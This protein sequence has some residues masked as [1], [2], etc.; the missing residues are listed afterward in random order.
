MR[1]P[2][3]LRAESDAPFARRAV[4]EEL[5]S[6]LL[7]SADLNPVAQ[8]TLLAPPALQGAEFRA[9][10]DDGSAVTKSAVAAVQRTNELIFIDP[11][12]PDREQ[13]LAGLTAQS[14]EGRQFEVITLDASR[15]GIAQVT[16]ALRG[17]IQVD[18]VHFITH[19]ADGAVQLGG[20]WLDAKTLAANA[21][22]VAG[23]GDS[24]K[25]DADVLF[26]GCDLASSAS[27]RALMQ[28][29]AELTRG[30]VAASTDATGAAGQGGD[31]DLEAKVG[32]IET[33]VAVAADARAS[34]SH[35]LSGVPVGS[36]KPGEHH[37]RTNRAGR[38][39]GRDRAG[40]SLRC[41]LERATGQDGIGR[42][43][44][45][46]LRRER[47]SAER[48]DPRQYDHR[49]APSLR[50]RSQ[51]TRAGNF[52]V[53]WSGNGQG[54]Q[55]R[56]VLRRFN[57]AGRIPLGVG[58]LRVNVA[59]PGNQS[60][61]RHRDGNERRLRRRLA[62]RRDR[63]I[64]IW[65]RR[66]LPTARAIGG[67]TL[68]FNVRGRR[69]FDPDDRHG[70]RR[71]FRRRVGEPGRQQHAVCSRGGT[72]TPASLRARSFPVN[73]TTSGEQQRPDVAMDADRQLRRRL[74]WRGSNRQQGR[75]TAGA[76]AAAGT[77]QGGEFRV[78]TLTG[79]DQT[80]AS[81]SMSG[82]GRFVVTW[83]SNDQDTD[84]LGVYAQEYAPTGSRRWRR[85]P[86]Q[87]H[88]HERPG[89][90]AVAMDDAGGYVAAWSGQGSGDG[91]GV[92]GGASSPAATGTIS[93]TVY[94]D[95][96][97]DGT[98]PNR[99]RFTFAGATVHLF[100]DDG[101]GAID[102]GDI[103]VGSILTDAAGAYSFTGLANSTY[104][105]VVDSKTLS[106]NPSVWAEQTYGV[107][108]SALGAGFTL[109]DGALFGGRDPNRLGQLDEPA[110]LARH[111]RA[112][113]DGD[114]VRR[115][116]R[117]RRF[118]VQLQ[119]DHLDS[120]RRRRRLARTVQGSLRQFIQNSNAIPN[121]AFGGGVEVRTSNFSIGSGPRT[122]VLASAL[123]AITDAVVLDAG[124]QEGFSGTPLIEVNG[125]SMGGGITLQS[126]SSGSV[127]RGFVINRFSGSGLFV[128]SGS[129]GNTIAGNWI[130]TDASGTA[131]QGNNGDGILI[132]GDDNVVTG[133]LISGNNNDGIQINGGATGNRVLGN[134]IG[135]SRFGD[136]A[137]ANTGAGINIFG[138]GNTVGGT[139]AGE[140][141]VISGNFQGISISTAQAVGNVVQGNYIGTDVTGTLD[142]GNTS[143]GVRIFD[144]AR[145]TVIGGTAPG[146]GNL[147]S[148]NNGD[149]LEI[150]GANT[151]G[152]LVQGNLIGTAAG[153]GGPRPNS[154]AGVRISAG[155]TDNTIGGTTAAE[156]NVISG[157]TLDGVAVSDLGTSRNVIQ[158]NFIGVNAA[159]TAALANGDA[160]VDIEAGASGN[161]VG[162]TVPGAGNVIS[163]N[164]VNGVE[165][166]G[167]GT[168]GNVVAGNT[169]GLNAV[170]DTAR[171]KRTFGRHAHRRVGQHDRRGGRRQRAVRQHPGRHHRIPLERQPDRGQLHRDRCD[172]KHRTGQRRGR[173][174]LRGQLEQHDWRHHAG[175]AERR[176]R[177][178]L[179]RDHALGGGVGERRSRELRRNRRDGHCA[180][181]QRRAGRPRR[182]L[183]AGPRSEELPP[184]PAT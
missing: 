176:L 20:T 100:R 99:A 57:A 155:A 72:T 62:E 46:A 13:L 149:G 158:G 138:G 128:A 167:A 141:N 148:G 9:L 127:V 47:H 56:R 142:R 5:E 52:V 8:E 71:R 84:N 104:Y 39:G 182:D 94:H 172:R 150:S 156:R 115:R 28:W 98:S 169:I 90:S 91:N 125:A 41:R 2:T 177:E 126:G 160:G 106:A 61:P 157:N 23:W 97:G 184:A 93:G 75:S 111:V 122:I 134:L 63:R 10:S 118:G 117:R 31:W 32:A 19:G 33:Q 49:A 152:N 168:T 161:V 166:N 96:D 154:G 77:P 70:R 44:R 59:I 40:R 25:Q 22:A 107:A 34:W 135:T 113:D 124:T 103:F 89:T 181:R 159:G 18:A 15:D 131:D 108:G 110:H 17:R 145:G 147:I 133:N 38:A 121:S 16:D 54:R 85:V 21:E 80:A 51:W 173:H 112:R 102:L 37:D 132:D 68:G 14:A 7:M 30:D 162:G 123:P 82:A 3:P 74:G 26:Y 165:L 43:V 42:R 69:R 58:E 174:L 86:G 95:V 183:G 175:S 36:E 81:V 92:F 178:R 83:E 136:V 163:G 140:R 60:S 55:R 53:A 170:G 78:S 137:L 164:A 114:A 35:V 50:P 101:D 119:R 11:R 27:G 180:A 66:Y 143:D 87:H 29:I 1:V 109:V 144:G 179:V 6:R 130:G 48:R 105:V 73:A 67:N 4:F 116:R 45:P 12:V 120:R 24:L 79:P 171:G 139:M 76:I 88:R 153:G 151:S 129:N 65:M 146:A 64:E